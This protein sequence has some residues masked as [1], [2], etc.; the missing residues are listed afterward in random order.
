MDLTVVGLQQEMSL[1]EKDS[2]H[3]AEQGDEQ[4]PG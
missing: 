4:E 3:Q 2:K 1:P